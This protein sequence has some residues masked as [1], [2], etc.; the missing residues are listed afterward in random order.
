MVISSKLWFV[1]FATPINAPLPFNFT[2][3]S[4]KSLLDIR[5]KYWQMKREVFQSVL[6]GLL[7]KGNTKEF[8]TELKNLFGEEVKLSDVRS[9]W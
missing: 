9:P 3:R 1:S 8:E 6:L 2:G 5:N 7:G 4:N